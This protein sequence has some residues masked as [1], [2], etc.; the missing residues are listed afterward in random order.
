MKK[1]VIPMMFF[2]CTMAVTSCRSQGQKNAEKASG[3]IQRMVKEHTPCTV[4][5]NSNGFFMKATINGKPW[6][7][8]E[9][10]RP[11]ASSR[12]IGYHNKESISFPFN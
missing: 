2:A 11:E 12:I 4:A 5:T 9:I 7:A 10:M 8:D 6:V 1:N 3:D